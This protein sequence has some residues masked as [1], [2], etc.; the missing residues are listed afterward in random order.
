M[1]YHR[2]K[3]CKNCPFR[4]DCRQGWLGRARS[5]Q[6]SDDLDQGF[7]CHKTTTGPPSK[8]KQCAGAMLVLDNI[9][10]EHIYMQLAARLLGFSMRQIAGK[11]LVFCNLKEF[12]DHHS[13]LNGTD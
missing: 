1:K 10:Q 2:T 12:V 6:I 11:N 3:P 9:G 7:I 13:D 5:Q 8:R 4:T